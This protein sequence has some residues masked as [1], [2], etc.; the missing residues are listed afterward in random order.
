MLAISY[1]ELM[2][3]LVLDKHFRKKLTRYYNLI[4]PF[5]KVQI[6]SY[7]QVKFFSNFKFS[8]FKC[9]HTQL[10]LEVV[11]KQGKTNSFLPPTFYVFHTY[12]FKNVFRPFLLTRF[13][14][15]KTYHTFQIG[16]CLK[17]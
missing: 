1:L 6:I 17:K 9:S 16:S 14:N 8:S 5:E 3:F 10:I 12:F 11:S 7:L 4:H 2:L 15:K 13:M